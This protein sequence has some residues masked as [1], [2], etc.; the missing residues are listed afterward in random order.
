MESQPRGGTRWGRFGLVMVPGVAASAAIGLALAQGALAASFAVSGQEFKVTADQLVGE[1]FVQYGS[2]ARPAGGGTEPVA[3]SAFDEATINNLCQSVVVP[4]VPFLG[5]VTLQLRA[6]TDPDN[7]VTA[8]N[9]FIDVAQL[10]TS[11]AVFTNVD[12]GVSV[13]DTTKGPEPGE[14]TL[15]GSFAQQADQVVLRDVE[16]TA[17]ATSAGTFRLSGLSM[18]LHTGDDEE[19]F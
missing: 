11:Q 17:W 2:I 7:P 16:Q 8:E 14:G 19:C 3:I 13:D 4:G 18:S 6:G 15:P 10:D 9:L 12:I 5:E 1:G